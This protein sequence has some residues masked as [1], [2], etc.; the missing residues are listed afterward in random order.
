MFKRFPA[1]IP[2]MT[3]WLMYVECCI[4]ISFNQLVYE[5]SIMKLLR[6]SICKVTNQTNSIRASVMR[7]H[8]LHFHFSTVSTSVLI[9]SGMNVFWKQFKQ[10]L[11]TFIISTS[12]KTH[13]SDEVESFVYSNLTTFF[14]RSGM[15]YFISHPFMQ[16]KHLSLRDT[17]CTGASVLQTRTMQ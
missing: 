2:N 1:E 10:R 14:T 8:L 5:S 6:S 15:S 17:Y 3:K 9:A 12:K 11:C 13:N 7:S 4:N 16:V